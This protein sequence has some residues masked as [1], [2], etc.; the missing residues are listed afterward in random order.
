MRSRRWAIALAAGVLALPGCGGG[1][2]S[3]PAAPAVDGAPSGRPIG[4]AH[5]PRQ[6]AAATAVRFV[7]GYLAFQAG[8][9]GPERVPDAS[10]Q[11]RRALRHQRIP[12][13][14][15]DRRAEVVRAEV[16][17][18]DARS[19]RV[20]VTVRNRDEALTY[21]LPIDL[22]RRQGSWLVLAAGDDT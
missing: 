5:D 20:A 16:N 14:Q 2:P 4:G 19:A 17:R 3:E 21:P 10:A 7:R 9:L 6:Q 13:A 18:I 15:R 12:P 22:V 8:R 1:S 11:L